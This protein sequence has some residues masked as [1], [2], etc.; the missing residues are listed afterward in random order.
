MKIDKIVGDKGGSGLID[1]QCVISVVE[2]KGDNNGRTK[3]QSTYS[4]E[5]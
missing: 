4:L 5:I 1:T 2:R 3:S